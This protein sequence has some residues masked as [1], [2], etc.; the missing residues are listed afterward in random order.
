MLNGVAGQC[1]GSDDVSVLID[2]LSFTLRTA[3][4]PWKQLHARSC[5]PQ[6]RS[7]RDSRTRGTAD[8]LTCIVNVAGCTACSAGRRS[9]VPKS[10]IVPQKRSGSGPAPPHDLTVVV[11]RNRSASSS[12]A[13]IDDLHDHFEQL[14]TYPF[15]ASGRYYDNIVK[16]DG[17]VCLNRDAR[18]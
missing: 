3:E 18:R 17:R 5:R 11:H 9:Q 2:S 15:L 16:I 4:S 14:D 10:A 6:E 13:E 12:R 1:A 7:R 8:D